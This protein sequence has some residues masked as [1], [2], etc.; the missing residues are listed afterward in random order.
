MRFVLCFFGLIASALTAAL[1]VGF[2]LWNEA[3]PTLQE[4]L[5]ADVLDAIGLNASAARSMTNVSYPNAGLVTL[6]AAA[7]GFLG[8]LL[9]MFRCGRQGGVLMLFA[10]L[11]AAAVNPISLV[12]TW[13][14]GLIGLCCLFIGPLPLN[15]P[16]EKNAEEDGEEEEEEEKPRPKAK[17]K[18]KTK[19]TADDDEE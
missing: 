9:T 7:Y 16:A 5:P 11:G 19:K 8:A 2:F 4:N 1:G 17:A 3:L 18:P 10:V 15:P 12:V 6:V 13:F 14:Q